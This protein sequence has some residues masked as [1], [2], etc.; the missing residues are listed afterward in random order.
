M[1]F[2]SK[3]DFQLTVP[4]DGSGGYKHILMGEEYGRIKPRK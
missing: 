1:L 4:K 3:V 2:Q